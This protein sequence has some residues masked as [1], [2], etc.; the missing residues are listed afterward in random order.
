MAT[1]K[2]DASHTNVGFSVRHMMVS[3]VRG[4]FTGVEGTLNGD[5]ADLTGAT[6]DFTID[7]SSIHS[8]NEDR[9]NHLRSADFFDVEKYPNITFKSTNIVKNGDNYNITGDMTI[10]DVTKQVT[11]EAEYLGSGKNPWGVDVAAFEANT[12]ISREEFG[13]TWNQALEAGGVL[14]GDKID[15]EMELQFNPEQ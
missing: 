1:W 6:I 12:Q 15:I 9:D 10:K 11:F 2:V 4:R 3:K 7:A 5:P 8:N 14:V 13:L